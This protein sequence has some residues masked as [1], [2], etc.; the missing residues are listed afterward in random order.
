MILFFTQFKIEVNLEDQTKREKIGKRYTETILEEKKE[1]EALKQKLEE[2]KIDPVDSK[3][4]LEEYYKYYTGEVQK[5]K[6]KLKKKD[7]IF[8][9]K[10]MELKRSINGIVKNCPAKC[11]YGRY[12]LCSIFLSFIYVDDMIYV[13]ITS[14]KFVPQSVVMVDILYVQC[15]Q[16]LHPE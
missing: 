5:L 1:L 11:G 8:H 9:V 7:R 13:M 3:K 6:A 10:K 4:G 2:I 16:V 12:S 15:L 14:S